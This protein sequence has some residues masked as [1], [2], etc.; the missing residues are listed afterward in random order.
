M[1]NRNRKTETAIE[2]PTAI[3]T[4]N[5]TQPVKDDATVTNPTQTAVSVI[6]PQVATAKVSDKLTSF[7]VTASVLRVLPG[8]EY[9]FIMSFRPT[10][11]GEEFWAAMGAAIKLHVK[12]AKAID[13][14][15][16]HVI[17]A[18]EGETEVVTHWALIRSD[19]RC[20]VCGN[21]TQTPA[22]WCHSDFCDAARVATP[23]DKKSRRVENP[24]NL[25]L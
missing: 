1:T 13:R 8:G 3:P 12:G 21:P 7:N 22:D 24:D 11:R 25:G 23:A 6:D 14:N 19:R 17:V 4:V 2:T 15:D 10:V 16:D 9:K 5:P 20:P 18:G